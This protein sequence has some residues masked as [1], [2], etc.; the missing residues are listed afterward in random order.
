MS[1][2]VGL[3]WYWVLGIVFAVLAASSVLCIIWCCFRPKAPKPLPTLPPRRLYS[4]SYSRQLSK[5]SLASQKSDMEKPDAQV[6]FIAI[7]H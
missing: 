6:P 3:Q 5:Y 4:P 2:G 7:G 1:T